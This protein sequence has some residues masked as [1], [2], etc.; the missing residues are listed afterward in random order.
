MVQSRFLQGLLSRFGFVT[1]AIIFRRTLGNNF[2]LFLEGFSLD[3][4]DDN[5][6][7]SIDHIRGLVLVMN[8]LRWLVTGVSFFQRF[9]LGYQ[10]SN[11]AP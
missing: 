8:A 6:R 2:K 11:S 7:S 1:A 5:L 3:C 9:H 10:D 4:L